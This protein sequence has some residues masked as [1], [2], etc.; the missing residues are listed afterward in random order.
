[1]TCFYWIE[2]CKSNVMSLLPLGYNSSHSLT[3]TVLLALKEASFQ[4]VA[5]PMEKPTWQGTEGSLWPTAREQLRPSVQQPERSWILP[6]TTCKGL[7]TDPSPWR[8]ECSPT[9]HPDH[10]PG[11]RGI[12]PSHTQIPGHRHFE[13]INADCWKLLSFGLICYLALDNWYTDRK[14]KVAE[15]TSDMVILHGEHKVTETHSEW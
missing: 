3:L 6:M 9:W 2:C 4:V 13:I 10:R 15:F 1:M 14:A 7:E 12:S 8:N 11:G 5:C